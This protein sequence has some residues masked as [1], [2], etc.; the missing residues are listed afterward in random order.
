MISCERGRFLLDGKPFFLY[1]GE[2]HYFRLR[3][4]EWPV[5]LRAA[6]AAGLNTVSSYV[7]WRW[8]EPRPGRTDFTGR[9]H[10]QRDLARY[11]DLV[12]EHGL[13]FIAR[14]G[15]VS[16]AEL[17]D[18]GVPRWLVEDHPEVFVRGREITNLPHT[19]MLAA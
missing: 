15:P 18:E 4:A 5:H 6:R 9:T 12:A 3:P 10:P 14:I 13:R 11:L 8:H 2:I 16:N 19:T 17:Q 1:S 7:P